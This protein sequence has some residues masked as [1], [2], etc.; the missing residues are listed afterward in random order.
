MFTVSIS[1]FRRPA[2][3]N[4]PTTYRLGLIV[5]KTVA[6]AIAG[7]LAMLHG[8]YLVLAGHRVLVA[9]PGGGRHRRRQLIQRQGEYG[10]LSHGTWRVG[11]RKPGTSYTLAAL[12]FNTA[13]DEVCSQ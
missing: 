13:G 5:S 8:S 9:L 10:W 11:I 2:V 12:P 6:S 3:S 4:L 7:W 1:V